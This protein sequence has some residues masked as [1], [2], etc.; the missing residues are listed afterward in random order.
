[1]VRILDRIKSFID[2]RWMVMVD[3]R[4]HEPVGVG[5]DFDV[6]QREMSESEHRGLFYEHLVDDRVKDMTVGQL[7]E[8]AQA[9]DRAGVNIGE[10]GGEAESIE[11][12]IRFERK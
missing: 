3:F 8:I 9:E 6:P 5:I 10:S 4:G 2:L 12:L 11:I 1:M 7:L